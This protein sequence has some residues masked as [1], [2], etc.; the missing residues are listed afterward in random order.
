MTR[1]EEIAKMLGW[2]QELKGYTV[3]S[4]FKKTD[5]S[6]IVAY[7]IHNNYP[8][9]DLPFRRDYNYLMQAFEFMRLQ[10]YRRKN[11]NKDT[12]LYIDRFEL[13]RNSIFLS[14]MICEDAKWKFKTISYIVG[15][16]A[17]TYKDAMFMAISDFAKIYNEFK[18]KNP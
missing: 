1:L 16:N 15:K 12:E 18:E 8:H 11:R 9:Q 13:N 10:A 5:V 2:Y 7:S 14:V 3:G 17:E 4:W 6:I